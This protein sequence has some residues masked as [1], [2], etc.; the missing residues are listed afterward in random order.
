MRKKKNKRHELEGKRSREINLGQSLISQLSKIG[1]AWRRGLFC[2]ALGGIAG[3][4]QQREQCPANAVAEG[5][6]FVVATL[7]ADTAEHRWIDRVQRCGMEHVFR[8]PSS[9][10]ISFLFPFFCFSFGR[11]SLRSRLV[12]LTKAPMQVPER[13]ARGSPRNLSISCF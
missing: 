9:L 10:A 12:Q 1:A 6:P 7:R 4:G 11:L 2:S 13:S 5:A 3:I 8:S